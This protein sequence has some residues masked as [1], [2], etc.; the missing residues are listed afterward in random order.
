MNIKVGDKVKIIDIEGLEIPIKVGDK[1]EVILKS[2]VAVKVSL[3][4]KECYFWI[5]NY[6]VEKI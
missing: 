5:E 2:N 1:G 4:D 6:R 3:L